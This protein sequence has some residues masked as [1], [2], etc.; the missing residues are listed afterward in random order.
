MG[1]T[2]SIR[3]HFR[4][5]AGESG[6]TIL[7][8]ALAAGVA[9]PHGCR[10]GN[11]GGCK[12]RLHAG[13]VELGP[14]SEYALSEAERGEGLILACR[15]MP[16]SDVTV[17]WLESDEIIVHPQ[18]RLR[19]RVVGLDDM[20]HDIKRL[21][22]DIEAGGPFT[23]SAGQFASLGFADLPARDYSM[24]NRPDEPRLEF[25]VRRMGQGA[26]AY[27]ADRLRLGDTV[28]V[29]GPLG[30]AF[31]REQ[32]GGPIVAI[33]GGSGLA[34]IK[35][36]VETALAAGTTQPIHLYFGARDECDIYLERD[37]RALAAAHGN[38]RFTPVLSEPSAATVRR[39]GLVHEAASAD[40]GDLDGAKAYLAGPPA[41]V[42]A[43]T[44]LLVDIRGMR[45]EDVH[46]DAFYSEAEKRAQAAAA[47]AAAA[48]I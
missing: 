34:P 41:M 22:L 35:S 14:Y 48:A 42:E 16:W 12:S 4:P 43:A 7:E 47:P 45:R 27:V 28:A 26:S 36:I 9:Y 32:R 37:F 39:R 11:C 19:C 46:A 30:S 31:L 23:F 24:A 25:H 15:A 44:R 8:A 3:Q 38:F 2:L 40:L 18:R 5:I 33:A 21:R 20:T 13:E 10:S 29:A 17:S 6:A 1:H